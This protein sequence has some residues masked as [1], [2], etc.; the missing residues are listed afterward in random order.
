VIS[1]KVRE[2][3]VSMMEASNGTPV[4]YDSETD[5]YSGYFNKVVVNKYIDLGALLFVEECT[6]QIT[7]LLN[8]RDDFLSSFA[9][10]VR[11]ASLGND[12]AY[13]DYNANPFAFSV[14]FEHYQQVIKKS[15][16]Y[17]SYLCHGFENPETGLIHLQ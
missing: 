16:K 6:G 10:G 9:A 11:E 17:L 5:Q 1:K 14:G 4:V 2:L 15:S 3:F 7:L 8:N 13:A 12:Q